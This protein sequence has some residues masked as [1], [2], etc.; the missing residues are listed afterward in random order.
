MSFHVLPTAFLAAGILAGVTS[1][2]VG[3]A[4]LQPS[5][6]RATRDPANGAAP[7]PHLKY[8]SPFATF[9]DSGA[10]EVA[11]W[12]ATNDTVGRIGGWRSYAR[13]AAGKGPVEA[14]G[15][16]VAPQQHEQ[17]HGAGSVSKPR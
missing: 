17:H 13:E 7:V 16:A 1:A 8:R 4:Q 11:P 14:S 6:Q 12:R 9:A 15:P 3:A 5:E 2:G 10:V